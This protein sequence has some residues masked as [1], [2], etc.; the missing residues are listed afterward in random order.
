MKQHLKPFVFAFIFAAFFVLVSNA[1]AQNIG[2][3]I[4]S[5]NPPTQR[6]NGE[7]LKSEEIGGY[8]VAYRKE[9]DNAFKEVIVRN[10]TEYAITVPFGNYEVKAQCFDTNGLYSNWSTTKKF[11][12]KTAPKKPLY[13][14]VRVV[15]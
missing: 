9:G 1:D 13:P 3:S 6:E 2:T 5:W 14:S 4:F 15:Q 7:T 12:V 10:A 8:V 11:T